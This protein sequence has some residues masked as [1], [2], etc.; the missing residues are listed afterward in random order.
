MA[1]GIGAVLASAALAWSPTVRRQGRLVITM[2]A[3]YGLTTILFGMTSGLLFA[4]LFLAAA[5][6]ADMVSTVMRQTIRQLTT[7]DEMRGRMSATSMLFH[8]T[9]PQLGDFEAGWL[10]DRTTIRFS[11]V[12]G[13]FGGLAVAGWYWVRGRALRQYVHGVSEATDVS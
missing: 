4:M 3:I 6:A 9:G 13:G 8:M 1:P 12:V 11:I 2:I 5:G 10:A 7:P